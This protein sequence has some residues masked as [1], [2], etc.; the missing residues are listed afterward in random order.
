MI[1]FSEQ[2]KKLPVELLQTL[3]KMAP[4]TDEELKLR[5]YTGDHSELGLAERFL[6]AL[7]DIPFAFQ[8]LEALLFM[9]SMPEEVS[10]A[11]ESFST[12]EVRSG[13]AFN[14]SIMTCCVF[15]F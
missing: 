15:Q 4:T 14:F 6:K 8:R 11:T 9:A 2:G 12:L 1:D 5:L 7:L 10:T 3:I 13:P